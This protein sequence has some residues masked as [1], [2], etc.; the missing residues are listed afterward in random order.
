MENSVD[1]VK[2]L[3]FK[4]LNSGF[5]NKIRVFGVK[6]LVGDIRR[7]I[8]DNVGKI[9]GSHGTFYLFNGVHYR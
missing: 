3:A 9:G 7:N 1:N 2:K 6:L 5:F 4:R 8:A